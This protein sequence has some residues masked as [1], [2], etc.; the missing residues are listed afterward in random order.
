M[1]R[2]QIPIETKLQVIDYIENQGRTREDAAKDFN[3]RL[4]IVS[5][6]MK[7]KDDIA[8]A[9][10]NQKFRCRR[11]KYYELEEPLME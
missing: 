6:I 2:N 9:Y 7:S 8:A 1:I 5:K 10:S 4:P 11:L 3:V